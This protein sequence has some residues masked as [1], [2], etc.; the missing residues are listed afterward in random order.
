MDRMMADGIINQRYFSL[1]RRRT[2]DTKSWQKGCALHMGAGASIDASRLDAAAVLTKEEAIAAAGDQWDEAKWE[3]AE[4]DE[5]GSIKMELLMVIAGESSS[6][7]AQAQLADT[8]EVA[9]MATDE[10]A[11]AAPARRDDEALVAARKLCWEAVLADDEARR[12]E[13]ELALAAAIMK[14]MG[15]EDQAEFEECRRCGFQTKAE[16]EESK[17]L[18]FE[19]SLKGKEEFVFGYKRLGFESKA[20]FDAYKANGDL[21]ALKSIGRRSKNEFDE[22]RASG[23]L[24]KLKD[25]GFEKKSDFDD[26][27]KKGFET[28]A[29]F[30]E[31]KKA[32]KNKAK[33]EKKTKEAAMREVARARLS[34]GYTEEGLTPS[35]VMA[36]V[37]EIWKQKVLRS[38]PEDSK[39]T[40]LLKAARQ[41]RADEYLALSEEKQRAM[42]FRKLNKTNNPYYAS[43]NA[44]L[45]DGSTALIRADFLEQLA[46]E[47]RPLGHR[48]E[49]PPEAFYEGPIWSD[50]NGD[51]WKGVVIVALSY[52]WG[53]PA[54]PDPHGEQLRDVARFLH[55]LQRTKGFTNHKSKL[56]AVMWDWASLYQDKPFTDQRPK[57]WRTD[58]QTKMFKTG[59]G[60]V[61]L[62]YCHPWTIT[63]MNRKTPAGRRN[64]YNIS[65]WPV[66]DESG[67]KE[68]YCSSTKCPYFSRFQILP[69]FGAPLL[70]PLLSTFI[71]TQPHAPQI[72]ERGVSYFMKKYLGVIDLHPFLGMLT[73]GDYKDDFV[74]MSRAVGALAE[75]APPLAPAAMRGKL[76]AST[77]TNGADEEFV[78]GK[79]EETFLAVLG[80]AKMLDFYR[81]GWVTEE[82][83]AGF[84]LEV[85]PCCVSLE[86]LDMSC[87]PNLKV[88]I[89]KLVAKLPPTLKNL[90][91][92][93]TGC[94]GDGGNANW[95]RLPALKEVMLQDTEIT[96]TKNKISGAGCRAGRVFL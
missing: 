4:K 95:A 23:D 50:S 6:K 20:A 46:A 45:A 48:A 11:T 75:A 78:V 83:W 49:L 21:E 72:F 32:E 56:V 80:Q 9:A 15:F 16:Y 87:N 91:L 8:P 59:L 28:K 68:R 65:G 60:N 37:K 27:Q 43:L 10:V 74:D 26:C 51:V 38:T 39:V 71:P 89:V 92:T 12:A 22:C 40:A 24:D 90:K 29:E 7:A 69:A 33:E 96:E 34:A 19:N 54:H 53:S 18:G 58:E 44:A 81:M 82:E 55:W 63:L 66:S 67:G 94:F 93:Q 70:I 36:K 76:K 17:C 41:A 13:A 88:D 84:C 30:D 52:M 31:A 25:M 61:N 77:F 79:Y 85:L 2:E 5:A 73:C 57:P 47:G 86:K 3:A 64:G 1:L 62:W 42:Q 35:G 14:S